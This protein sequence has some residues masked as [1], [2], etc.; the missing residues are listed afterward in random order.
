MKIYTKT[1]DKGFTS[2]IG[3]TRVPKHHIRIESYG[4]VDELNSYIGL[5]GDQDID[6]HDKEVLKQIQDRLFTI[7]SS[8]AADPERS[9]MII[10]DLNMSDVEMLEA[11]MDT[12]NESLPALKHFILPGG[13][14]VISF[15]HIARCVCRRAE[16]IT[17][18]LAEESTVDEKVNIYL[19]RLSDYLFTLARKIANANK[20]AENQWIPRV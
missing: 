19:N 3:G 15:C 6:A 9:R 4:T 2:L 18:Q 12:M 11:E 13:S 14:N 5:I 8:L 16:R 10:P 1:G 20:I 7:G 17:V